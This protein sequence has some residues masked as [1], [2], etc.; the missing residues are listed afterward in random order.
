MRMEKTM[1]WKKTNRQTGLSSSSRAQC[2]IFLSM[3]GNKFC[4]LSAVSAR[5][6]LIYFMKHAAF[7]EHPERRDHLASLRL[8]GHAMNDHGGRQ[9]LETVA[10]EFNISVLFKK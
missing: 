8:T 7:V 3:G 2:I 9:H 4:P 1:I 10:D 5:E 6:F